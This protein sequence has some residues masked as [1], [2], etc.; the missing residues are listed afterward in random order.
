M[1][2]YW[3]TRKTIP[4]Y[5]P[6]TICE[7]KYSKVTIKNCDAPRELFKKIEKELLKKAEDSLLEF[8]KIESPKIPE[9]VILAFIRVYIDFE[10]ELVPDIRTNEYVVR[11]NTEWKSPDDIDFDCEDSKLIGEYVL[12]EL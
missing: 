8:Y 11:V 7:L 6:H 10:F 12:K 4:P 2:K 3:K 9:E 1:S 5:M